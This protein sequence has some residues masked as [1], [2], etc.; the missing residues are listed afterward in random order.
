MK[1]LV[2]VTG[3]HALSG[4]GRYGFELSQA[5]QSHYS[6]LKWLKPCKED[7]PDTY[8][9]QE[10]WIEGYRYKSFRNLHPYV[11]P[12]FIKK[13]IRNTQAD[14]LHA[15][16][17]LSGLGAIKSNV[18]D[19]IIV[20][21]HDVSLLHVS[22][23]NKRYTSYYFN[24][25]EQFKKREIP[26]V[27]VSEKARQDA[28]TY[29]E[30]PEELVF[31]IHNG[32]NHQQF[33]QTAKSS[34]N[35]RFQIIYAGGLGKRKNVD[36]LLRVFKR[37]EEKFTDVDLTII[38]AHPDRTGLPQLAEELAIQHVSFPG[39]LPDEQ[40]NNFYNTGDLLVFP[41]SYEGFGFTPLEA[42]ACGT[43][44]ISTDGGALPETAGGGALISTM[45]QEDLFEK[46]SQMIESEDLRK[47]YIAKGLKWASHFTWEQTAIAQKEMY[48]RVWN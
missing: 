28:I 14:Y 22:E 41:S 10:N 31:A 43:P 36:L 48:E 39:F 15:H 2:H 11:L 38:G 33:Y 1:N 45:E 19:N 13:G 23:Q 21:M 24:A 16:W 32:I 42:M 35:Q 9:H 20:T 25:I 17:F 7:H 5:L 37:I 44:V 46:I 18:T 47:T 27:T 8:L 29:T 3:Q 40:M 12:F 30:Y 4:I 34:K 26:I 6:D